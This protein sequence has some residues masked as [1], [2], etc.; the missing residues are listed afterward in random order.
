M[1]T[2]VQ[3]EGSLDR[4][5]A[6][7]RRQREQPPAPP[8]R[9]A[10][11][12]QGFF[13]DQARFSLAVLAQPGVGE[14]TDPLQAERDLEIAFDNLTKLW[15]VP[16]PILYKSDESVLL[17]TPTGESRQSLTDPSQRSFDPNRPTAI[18][19][20]LGVVGAGLEA[21]QPGLEVFAS[22]VSFPALLSSGKLYAPENR[23][24]SLVDIYRETDM[25]RGVKGFLENLPLFAIPG[26]VHS[27]WA[28]LAQAVRLE[29]QGGRAA[30]AVAHLLRGTAAT[31]RPMA[32]VETAA[33]GA[34]TG[35]VKG[36]GAAVG[37]ATRRLVTRGVKPVQAAGPLSPGDDVLARIN[38]MWDEV[39]V[40]ANRRPPITERIGN[41]SRTFQTHVIDKFAGINSLMK[42]ARQQYQAKF[43]EPMPAVLDAETQAALLHGGGLSGA[44]AKLDTL[45]KAITKSL[46]GARG[47]LE[48][49]DLNTFLHLRHNITLLELTTG[50]KVA[51]GLT[52]AEVE[53]ALET[54]QTRLGLQG[55]QKIDEAAALVR[56]HWNAAL[57]EEVRTGL[58]SA[59]LATTL[60]TKYPFYNPTKFVDDEL[61]Q[62]AAGGGSRALSVTA[63]DV[64]RLTQLGSDA[65]R[66]RP[67]DSLVGASLRRDMLV[68][69]NDAARAII[70]AARLNPDVKVNQIT[71]LVRVAEVEGKPI[72]R[73]IKGEVRGTISYME[74]GKRKVWEVPGFI[75]EAA[76]NLAS[77]PLSTVEIPFR[78]ANAIPRA[79][80][81]VFNPAFMV[82]NFT[83]DMMTVATTRGILPHKVAISLFKNLRGIIR[84]DPTM[85]KFIEA[86]ADVTGFS[87]KDPTVVARNAAKSGNFVLKDEASWRNLFQNPLKTLQ[88]VGHAIELS[89]RRAVIENEIRKGAELQH[90]VL[91]GRRA[92]VDFSRSG[93]SLRFFNSM[94]LYLNA[95]LQGAL[96]PARALRDVPAARYGLGAYM[97]A[98]VAAYAWNRQFP[99]YFDIPIEERLGRFIVMMPSNELNERGDTVPHSATII[100]ILREFGAISG[101]MVYALGKMDERDPA[102][103]G[104]FLS[105]W[106]PLANPAATVV[107]TASGLTGLI[108]TY[109]GQTITEIALNQDFFWNREIVPPELEGLPPQEQFDEFSSEVSIRVGQALNWSPKKLDHI[110]RTGVGWDIVLAADAFLRAREGRDP[111]IEALAEQLALFQEVGQPDEIPTLRR[112]FLSQLDAETRKAVLEEERKPK[113]RLPVITSITNSF[114]RRQGGQ[115]YRSGIAQASR[116]L[117]LSEAQTREVGRNL[118]L[119]SDELRADQEQRDEA[120]SQWRELEEEGRNPPVDMVGIASPTLWRKGLAANADVWRGVI[121]SN[122]IRFP[123]AVQVQGDPSTREYFN[124]LVNTMLGAIPDQR[125]RGQVLI[126]ALNGIAP[127]ELAPG[128]FDMPEFYEARDAFEASLSRSDRSILKRQRTANY[129]PTRLEYD[130]DL[131]SMR[132]YWE[133]PSTILSPSVYDLYQDWQNRYGADKADFASR[134]PALEEGIKTVREAREAFREDRTVEARDVENLLL[135]W[136]FLTTRKNPLGA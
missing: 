116:A 117:N 109:I 53:L 47:G 85:R 27:R 67:L 128:I 58:I 64:K 61:A 17:E 111:E 89:P 41:A 30:L 54:L 131:Q 52:R 20:A 74:R 118:S 100:P 63:N 25:P 122:A 29:A 125:T 123:N 72:F 84:E 13:I 86:G 95:G 19:E 12:T 80:L 129:S 21:I 55:M 44:M 107:D 69:R 112:E 99:E 24:K 28:L 132:T 6:S 23:G 48:I 32:T 76:K 35:V 45:Q 79:L 96:L 104:E 70:W 16:Q 120:L 3:V 15:A 121:L 127:R 49:D 50:R 105:A 98:N 43:G 135:K 14:Q 7:L 57:N 114:Y 22:L 136:Q 2:P 119:A 108:P 97:A 102:S 71:K 91:Q 78:M 11:G 133:I 42:K 8:E 73:P 36:T 62:V 83:F 75:E 10:E 26:A 68:R 81:T 90:A 113:A 4:G 56:D 92:T 34:V 5:L 18:G 130:K 1:V 59:Q 101:P 94:Y 103:M 126:A 51:G 31:I 46:G 65:L 39:D 93:A 33:V 82:R 37:A 110:L 66:E 60:K 38:Q 9:P 134:N 77:T 88:Q 106:A 87:G 124:Q 40:I 115:Y